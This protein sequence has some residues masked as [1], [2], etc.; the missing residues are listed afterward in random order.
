MKRGEALEIARG[1]GNVFRDVGHDNADAGQ[2]KAILA[3]DIVKVLKRER[4][5]VRAAHAR[6][7]IA[8]AAFSRIRN[9]DLRRFTADRLIAVL[10]SPELAGSREGTISVRIG[11]VIAGGLPTVWTVTSFVS[12]REQGPDFMPTSSLQRR[13]VPNDSGCSGILNVQPGV[14]G[15]RTAA[16]ARRA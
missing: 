12:I 13:S 1:T 14:N 7:G 10:K 3:A 9:A 15:L 5:T 6:T 11:A 4:L 16:L 8:A 2:L